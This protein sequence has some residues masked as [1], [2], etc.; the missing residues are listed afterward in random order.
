M[1][2]PGQVLC[3]GCATMDHIFAVPEIPQEPLKYRA[4]DFRAVGGGNAATAAVTVA[5]L[6]GRAH[7]IARLGDDP[8]G[9]AILRELE[10]YGVDTRL[11]RR[12]AGCRSH[13]AS[14]LIDA[15]GDRLIVSYFDPLIGDETDWLPAIPDG[16]GAVLADAHWPAGDLELF[17][18]AAELA[19]PAV[20]DA[21]MPSCAPELIA[22]STVAAFSAPGLEAATAVKGIEAGLHAAA[23]MGD[24]VMLATDGGNGVFWLENGAVRHQPAHRVPA[25]DTLGA[26]DVFHGALALALAEGRGIPGAVAFAN[27]AAA[28]KV[29]RFGGRAGAPSRQEVE[30]LM[31]EAR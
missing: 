10:D 28:I 3:M 22:A 5:R 23:R 29:T 1:T 9:D 27:A 24:G 6:G 21:D 20:L 4:R 19:I 14:I 12:F 18:R 26:G 15:K 13:I 2:K 8:M 25:V 11:V 16:A 30:S 17:R 31:A 7:L